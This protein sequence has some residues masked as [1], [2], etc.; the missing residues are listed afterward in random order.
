MPL[1]MT[2]IDIGIKGIGTSK[3]RIFHEF[4]DLIRIF[5]FLFHLTGKKPYFS[6][7]CWWQMTYMNFSLIDR[8]HTTKPIDSIPFD[9]S[10]ILNRKQKRKSK[11]ENGIILSWLWITPLCVWRFAYTFFLN[12]NLIIIFFPL[13]SFIHF[14]ISRKGIKK[15]R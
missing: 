11:E 1:L 7:N 6:M 8:F 15:M 13:F 2:I 10:K 12:N 4:D 9:N 14:S 3:I 5:F